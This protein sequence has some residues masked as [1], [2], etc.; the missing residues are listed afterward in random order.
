MPD[1][2]SKYSAPKVEERPLTEKRLTCPNGSDLKYLSNGIS[3][4]TNGMF[5][6]SGSTLTTGDA[7]KTW[8]AGGDPDAKSAVCVS[9]SDDPKGAE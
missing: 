1:D 9:K 6:L 5:T 7:P 4:S 8:Q 2:N 3:Y